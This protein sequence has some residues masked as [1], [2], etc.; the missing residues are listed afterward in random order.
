MV[1]WIMTLWILVV[2]VTDKP[3]S[4]LRVRNLRLS[5]QLSLLLARKVPGSDS[6]QCRDYVSPMR[7]LPLPSTFLP[8]HYPLIIVTS[9][10]F[11]LWY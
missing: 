2:D 9:M 3:L 7:P 4:F 5:G 8:F 6:V 11:R 1:F 10:L